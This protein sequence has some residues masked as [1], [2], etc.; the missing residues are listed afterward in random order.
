MTSSILLVAGNETQ[1][2]SYTTGDQGNV[3]ITALAG[4]GWVVT[5]ESFGQDGSGTGLYQQRYNAD[6][7]VNGTETRIN[8]TTAGDQ[9]QHQVTGLAGG[10]WVVSWVAWNEATNGFA[11][12][13]QA[14]NADGS[15]IRTETMVNGTINGGEYTPKVTALADGGWVVTW[16]SLEADHMYEIYQ[17]VYHSTGRT[18][19]SASQVNTTTAGYQSNP[20][21]TALY[22]GGWVVTWQ[23]TSQDGSGQGVYQQAFYDDGTP[24]GAE[25]RVNTTTANHQ[26]K[27]QV[28]ALVDGGW[29]ISWQSGAQDGSGKGIYQQAY[30]AD[31]TK[32]GAETR[33]NTT[34]AGDQTNQLVT[35]LAN[36]GWLVTW[37]T[38][39]ATGTPSSIFQQAYDSGGAPVGSET[40]VN[41]EVGSQKSNVQITG[42]IGGGW[43]VTWES[44]GQDGSGAGIYQKVYYADG[45]EYGVEM[46]VNATTSGDQSR[47]Q[48]TALADGGWLISWHSYGQDGSERGVYQ[49]VYHLNSTLDG[50][51]GNDTLNGGTGNDTLSGGAGI[52][53]MT[54]HQGDDIYIADVTGDIV[55]EQ[56]N[57]GTDLVKY[58]GAAGTGYRLP[59]NVENLTLTGTNATNAYGNELANVL[60]GNAAANILDGGEGNDTMTGGAGN[61]IYVVD[62]LDDVVTENAGEGTDTVQYQG[63][64]GTTYVLGANIENL[65]LTGSDATNATGNA[66]DNAITGNAAANTIDGGTGNDTM[67]GGAGN[68]TYYVDS[69]YDVVVEGANGGTD[70]VYYNGAEG[71]TYT[72]SNSVENLI[73]G[74]TKAISGTGN[75]LANTITGNAAANTLNGGAGD[76]TLIGGLGDDVYIVDSVGD[77]IVENSNGGTDTVYYYGATGTTCVLSGNVENLTL[78]GTGAINGTGNS[79]NNLIIGN[80]SNNIL[81]GGT[82]V[83][84][85]RGGSGND[86][87]LVDGSNDVVEED[88]NRGTDTV[89][90][91]GASGTTYTLG[92]NVENLTLGGNS[93]T[94][95]TGNA[96]DNVL[97]GNGSSNVL[98]GLD[99]NDTLDGG[100]GVDTLVGGTGNDSYYVDGLSDVI[101]ENYNEGIDTVY[102]TGKAKNT[103]V[104]GAYLENLTLLGTAA[105]NATGNDSDNILTGNDAANSLDGGAGNDTLIGG[106]GNDTYLV[107]SSDDVI[108]ELSGGGNDTVI[109][110]G[111]AGST[112]IL[113][114]NVE[115]LKLGGTLATNGTGNAENNLITGNDANNALSGLAGDDTLDGG[116]GSDTLTGGDGDDLYYAD[117]VTDV[118]I[119]A[120]A[121]GV[122]TVQYNGV[123]GTTYVL[124][125]NVEN[126]ILT[127]AA[128]TNG[129]GNELDNVLTGNTAANILYGLGGNDTLDGGAGTDTLVGGTGDDVYYVGSTADVVTEL[130]GEGNDTIRFRGGAGA[131][132]K[133]RDNVENLVLEGTAS[134]NATGNAL[135]NVITGNAGANI[136]DGGAGIDTLIGGGG[137]DTYNVDSLDDII[138]ELESEGIDTV[139]YTGVAGSTYILGDNLERLTLTGNAAANATGNDLSNVLTGNSANN[140]LDGGTGADTLAGGAG[141]DTY[142]VNG[143]NDIII[144]T[145][146]NGRDV[147]YFEGTAGTTYTLSANVENLVLTGDA[148]TNAT[149]NTLN[150]VLTG[151]DAANILTGGGGIDTM[152]GGA[153]DDTYVVDSIDDMVLEG[154]NE[155]DD[156]VQYAG[157]AGTTYVLAANVE[158]LTLTGTAA[159][160]GT[161]NQLDNVITGNSANNILYGGG[162]TDTLIGGA[163]NDTYV[164]TTTDDVLT[165]YASQGIDSVQYNGAT[166][167][168]YT[169]G[170]N[171]E[172][173]TLTGTNATNGTGNELGNYLVGN[174]RN[175]LLTGLLGNDTMQ[176][177]GGID[178][179][180]G[181][182]GNDTYMVD[183][184]TDV[185][186]ENADEGIDLILFDAA[187]GATYTLGANFENLTITSTNASNVTGNALNNLLIGNAADNILD[188]GAGNDTL[189]GGLGNDTYY[190][191]DGD[192]VTEVSGVGT[193]LVYYN[194]S[195]ETTFILGNYIENL[196][197]V[198]NKVMNGTGNTQANVIVG[199]SA[200]NTLN[201]LGGNDTLTG[202]AGADV[203]VFST[204]P[205][206]TSNV[207][208]I[209]DFSVVDDTIHLENAVF[210]A[211]TNTGLLAS[212][213]FT[214][215][216]TGL[217]T[218]AGQR[219][220]YNSAT[221]DLYYD[222]NGSAAGGSV[223]V[224]H[225]SAN[226]ALTNLDFF[227]I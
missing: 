183:S 126:L 170:D 53:T 24:M 166:G 222:T 148:S 45:S 64:S 8:T 49:R 203:F 216:T 208:T 93:A 155:G 103:Y 31:G 161:G 154:D 48:V 121:Q 158:R 44:N 149:G 195:A 172:Y 37:Q 73:L 210:T 209:T 38:Y 33:V 164:V 54:G 83:D 6:G 186:T 75:A 162:G 110:T 128:K 111:T 214:S 50:T 198:G 68:D 177:G 136:L 227:V 201:G 224:A 118:V 199:N 26:E 20:Q 108:T 151:N 107:N 22:D 163:G 57:E 89:I 5:W 139:Q 133:L 144:E 3:S 134:T 194:G 60:T 192:V 76:D 197:L 131:T 106:G 202:G 102:F 165:E 168:T 81:N 105:T 114:D 213:L 122:D 120:A 59:D 104:L 217:A 70:T 47:P 35:T 41:T 18:L 12:Y 78:A 137:N 184:T 142:Y 55:V 29:V 220:I 46:L 109:F 117:A 123:L 173:L 67:S 42:L 145:A 61:D 17:Q 82:G 99:G 181:G 115:I 138:S 190:V 189:Q 153:D 211:L 174:D 204:A 152:A 169:L 124:S 221:G 157:A 135:D 71:T 9:T 85:L 86:I 4:G 84:T 95:A 160:N 167:T 196:T 72:L 65:I 90:Y 92:A 188:G 175:N 185:L 77:V 14:Y 88:A 66:L 100:T 15:K 98:T 179:L 13:Q 74:G 27:Q 113:S 132:Y 156:L 218:T 125:A 178:T 140:I 69:I 87:Y 23:S 97:T 147:V 96:L 28:T 94:R 141:D 2:N 176:G 39:G 219:V 21:I 19:G 146:N 191:D 206:A 16:M 205:N 225:L 40:Q 207:D 52:N 43:I 129:T 80:A 143:S 63:A 11:A 171:I 127:G 212:D 56:W 79:R 30:H 101:I 34:V 7:T 180:I 159:S 182:V 51:A 1:V 215:N 150:N 130:A 200:A 36:G 223:L 32:M 62:S 10:G 193:D 116:K 226:L 187:Y 119:E 25:T 91:T 112:Y 58:G